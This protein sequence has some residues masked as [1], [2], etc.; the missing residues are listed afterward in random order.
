HAVIDV[1]EMLECC[2]WI[3]EKAQCNPAGH[4]VKLGTVIGICWRGGAARHLICGCCI[5]NIE[6]LAGQHATFA[7]PFIGF[8]ALQILW[9]PRERQLDRSR[10]VL[11]R[12]YDT[13]ADI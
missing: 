8:L 6:K 7:P 9:R 12:H 1:H 2:S 4:E 10:N 5:A 3:V 13:A 11:L